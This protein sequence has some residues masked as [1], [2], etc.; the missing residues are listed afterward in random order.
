MPVGIAYPTPASREALGVSTSTSSQPRL[1]PT[2][3]FREE[4]WR[5]AQFA[6][7]A[8]G[9]SLRLPARRIIHGG[10]ERNPSGVSLILKCICVNVSA[11]VC[12]CVGVWGFVCV[13]M[14]VCVCGT[15]ETPSC[16]VQ[17]AVAEPDVMFKQRNEPRAASK[18][19][20][21]NA[22][23]WRERAGGLSKQQFLATNHP[24][25]VTVCEI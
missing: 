20:P 9:A 3:S 21:R 8:P 11:S 10:R 7:R 17:E 14:C 18:Q 15:G 6:R 1:T 23:P 5:N 12:R 2:V 16:Q 4:T 22:L 13:C 24:H 25:A 19:L